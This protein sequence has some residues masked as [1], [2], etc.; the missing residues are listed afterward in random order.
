MRQGTFSP[1]VSF[2][3][4]FCQL[5]F[6]QKLQPTYIK[7]NAIHP[8]KVGKT[9]VETVVYFNGVQNSMKCP[10]YLQDKGWAMQNTLFDEKLRLKKLNDPD[11]VTI[12]DL[13]YSQPVAKRMFQH[14]KTKKQ[15]KTKTT[16]ELDIPDKLRKEAAIFLAN[17]LTNVFN[18]CPQQGVYPRIWKLEY[19]TPVPKKTTKPK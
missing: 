6:H 4:D 18:S 9:T 2:G 16:L 11:Y 10:K 5:T 13:D 3:L 7:G 17:P 12:K 19:V 15:K 1:L 8:S 14:K